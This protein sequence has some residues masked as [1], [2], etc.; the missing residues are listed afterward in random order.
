MSRHANSKRKDRPALFDGLSSDSNVSLDAA[1][2]TLDTRFGAED[3][4]SS[5]SPSRKRA[6][7]PTITPAPVS[8]EQ[9]EDECSTRRTGTLYLVAVPIGCLEDMS[10]R[11]LR[12]LRDSALILCENV[13]VSRSLAEHFGIV[14]SLTRY[15]RR[16]SGFTNRDWLDRLLNGE[17]LALVCDAGTPGIADPGQSLVRAALQR[18]LRVIAIPGP[19]AALVALV[20]SGLSTE[21]FAFDGFPP[22]L[23]VARDAFFRCLAQE[24]RTIV[25]YE[26]AAVLVSTLA[27]LC[28][29]GN[30]V[31]RI[32]IA[33]HLTQPGEHW[34]RGTLQEALA[35]FRKHRPRGEYTLV[36]EGDIKPKSVRQTA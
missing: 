26:S 35:Y 5:T 8:S 14:T 19:S 12:I 21:R 4:F 25:L 27:A 30:Q 15:G 22:R 23:H 33:R 9:R 11:A 29:G 17:D 6:T 10:L 13:A 34:F 1:S 32:A 36:I 20:A 2:S 24:E 31:R 7:K 18:S 3:V 28:A 16:A